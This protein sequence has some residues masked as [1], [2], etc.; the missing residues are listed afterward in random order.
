[1][2]KSKASSL[3][4][5]G[6]LKIGKAL[7]Y[8]TGNGLKPLDIEYVNFLYKK[9][10]CSVI[11]TVYKNTQSKMDII[12]E[13][14]HLFSQTFNDF[15]RGHGCPACYKDKKLESFYKKASDAGYT[16]GEY[17]R[18]DI[19]IG[20]ICDKGHAGKVKPRDFCSGVRCKIC[21]KEEIKYLPL[22]LI[23]DKLNKIGLIYLEGYEGSLSKITVKCNIGHISKRRVSDILHCSAHNCP[24]CAIQSKRMD[25]DKLTSLLDKFGFRAVNISEYKNQNS[26][27]DVI[28]KNGHETQKNSILHIQG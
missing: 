3:N 10:G 11:D 28:C 16:F 5:F 14:Q 15:K 19:Q 26:R 25:L 27:I 12:C 8:K 21:K 2:A 18:C 1:M 24:K 6:L 9:E 20:F 13:K 17:V 22:S 7:F 4:N 23:T